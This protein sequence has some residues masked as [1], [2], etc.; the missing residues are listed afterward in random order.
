MA[1]AKQNLRSIPKAE[2][3]LARLTQNLE[4]TRALELQL[5][6]RVEQ[7]RILSASTV[8][9]VRIL[10]PA[11]VHQ[12]VGPNRQNPILIGL[13]TSFILAAFWVLVRNYFHTG[14]EDG[15]EIEALGFSLFGT[16]SKV[17]GITNGIKNKNYLIAKTEPTSAIVE[18]F[19]G[20]R[21]A[22]G[23]TLKSGSHKSILITSCAPGDG[24]SFVSSNLAIIMANNNYNTLLIDCDM[25]RG[26]LKKAFNLPKNGEGLSEVLSSQAEFEDA[27]HAVNVT[28]LTLI[29]AGKRPPN[30]AE[31]LDN[32]RMLEL[33][34][35]AET[36]FDLIILDAPPILA[37]ADALILA[38]SSGVK[39]MV[40]KHKETSAAEASTA[41]KMLEASG[42][43]IN[44]AILNSYDQ[45][46]SKYGSYSYKYEYNYGSYNYNY[47]K[48]EDE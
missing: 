48:S 42:I 12:Q 46:K 15:R 30:P 45:K 23:F 6:E 9:N 14:I 3:T 24:K 39:L 2:Q 20:L 11:E 41:L 16:I 4:G 21:T 28:N 31:L 37:V 34:A 5:I 40:I 35:W 18:A 36:K 17:P 47:S 7:L 26:K 25:R 10:E 43:R 8:G 13:L 32:Q 1:D 19:R 27:C 44:G 22:L 33:F 29:P 38:K